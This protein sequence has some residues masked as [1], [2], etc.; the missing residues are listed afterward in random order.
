MVQDWKEQKDCHED[1]KSNFCNEKVHSQH[2]GCIMSTR[3]IF[4]SW[5]STCPVCSVSVFSH[6]K[7]LLSL[8]LFD[9]DV[10][11]ASSQQRRHGSCSILMHFVAVARKQ[12]KP[13]HRIFSCHSCRHTTV[14]WTAGPWSQT[15]HTKLALLY[16]SC[17]FS[18]CVKQCCHAIRDICHA[19][20]SLFCS[21]EFQIIHQLL[22][23]P[24]F[25]TQERYVENLEKRRE[26]L[27]YVLSCHGGM[28]GFRCFSKEF[29]PPSCHWQGE[30]QE[31]RA[32][33]LDFH[34]LHW[35]GCSPSI[36]MLVT[37]W[38]VGTLTSFDVLCA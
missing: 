6:A 28:V 21:W 7:L 5:L 15:L 36:A 20:S 33:I 22:V 12:R 18:R 3:F 27:G 1:Q 31:E 37:R 23:S 35:Q 2:D 19:H 14:S 11:F 29:V 17:F 38:C 26:Q 30:Q 32:A 9:L 8:D 10:A 16:F 25:S 24:G 34:K 4:I 13:A